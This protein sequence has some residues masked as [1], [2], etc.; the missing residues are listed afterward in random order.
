LV[1]A[2]DTFHLQ[3]LLGHAE[4]GVAQL[5]GKLHLLAQAVHQQAEAALATPDEV[6]NDQDRELHRGLPL[7]S[8]KA[9]GAA[10]WRAGAKSRLAQI[11][12][13]PAIGSLF[14]I[15]YLRY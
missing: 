7:S 6:G 1:V 10:E 4:A 11:G 3:V 13:G 15:A 2:F 12:P 14:T 5:L 9:K 8:R